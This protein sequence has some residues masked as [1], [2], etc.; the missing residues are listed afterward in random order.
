MIKNF[1]KEINGLNFIDIGSSGQ[2]DSKWDSLKPFISLIGFDPNGD[3]CERMASL[4][5]TFLDLKYLPF[6]IAG[7]TGVQKLYKTESIYCYSLL[8]PNT[9]WLNRFSFFELFKIIGSEEVKTVK[10]SELDDLLSSATDIIKVDTQGLE[11]PILSNAGKVLDDAFLVETETGFVENYIG[12]TTYAEIDIFMRSKGFLLFDI[13]TNHRISRNNV[14]KDAKTNAEQILWCEATWLKDY[15]SLIKNDSIDVKR[16]DRNK[17][18]K[19]LI[20]CA[21]LKCLD[22]GY[23]LA[24]LFYEMKLLTQKELNSLKETY[25]WDIINKPELKEV[26][27]HFI[28]TLLRFLPIG[29]RREISEQAKVAAEQ[30]HIFRK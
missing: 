11:L 29:W 7:E 17:A 13:N 27:N 23:E 9:E 28:S 4:P 16:I 6:A 8:K 22:F 1:L 10:L 15:V 20:V 18:L 26:K 12:E 19:C 30:R 14:F 5:N 24:E 3:E 2:L 21:S 25:S